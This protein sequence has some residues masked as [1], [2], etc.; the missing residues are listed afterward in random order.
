MILVGMDLGGSTTKII[1]KREHNYSR[2]VLE[3]IRGEG[4]IL[5]YLRQAIS[6]NLEC[7]KICLC[8]GGAKSFQERT[9]GTFSEVHIICEMEAIVRGLLKYHIVDGPLFACSMGSGTSFIH[10]AEDKNWS[11]IGG[12]AFGGGTATGLARMAG[13][14]T[15]FDLAC[16]AR[17]GDC[18]MVNLTVGDIY[19][20]KGETLGMPASVVAAYF[21]KYANSSDI[22]SVTKCDLAKS[23]IELVCD[24]IAQALI[25]TICSEFGSSPKRHKVIFCGGFVKDG[26]LHLVLILLS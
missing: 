18:G 2:V 9:S 4:E 8:G 22:S 25:W 5:T 23:I 3:N 6:D 24:S 14:S 19:N 17:S 12:T 11:R 13:I 1:I 7:L 16:L 21:A 10:V 20:T 15:Y 26:K